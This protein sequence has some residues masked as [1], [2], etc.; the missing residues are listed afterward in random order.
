MASFP[1]VTGSVF[2][3]VSSGIASNFGAKKSD[4]DAIIGKVL[5]R[6]MIGID[7]HYVPPPAK[8]QN[9]TCQWTA[10]SSGNPCPK[11]VDNEGDIYC[12][13]HL[14]MK[15]KQDELEPRKKCKYIFMRGSNRQCDK[16]ASSGSDYCS[17]HKDKVTKKDSSSEDEEDDEADLKPIKKPVKSGKVPK[18]SS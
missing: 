12:A 9:P 14:K 4:I 15:Q 17:A 11:R 1:N 18:H 5:S 10:R 7:A 3:T 6:N 8:K 16:N 2:D 13:A